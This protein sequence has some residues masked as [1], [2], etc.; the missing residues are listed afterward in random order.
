MRRKILDKFD[1]ILI[2]V[3]AAAVVL[4]DRKLGFSYVILLVLPLALACA[5]M[6]FYYRR[7]KLRT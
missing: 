1:H 5:L 6:L 4:V 7:R 3:C 2:V